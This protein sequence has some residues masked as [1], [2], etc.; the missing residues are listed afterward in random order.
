MNQ[1][2]VERF[3]FTLKS[4]MRGGGPTGMVAAVRH[5][6]IKWHGA[7]GF[8]D[9]DMQTPLAVGSCF[10]IYSVSKTFTAAL[11][12]KLVDAGK[13]D[14]DSQLHLSLPQLSIPTEVT[15]R[16]LLNHTSGIPDYGNLTEY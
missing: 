11:V 16:Q 15:V 13:L 1:S 8:E 2:L 10:L 4:S 14:L 12:L 9:I 3:N 7:I 6:K 5:G